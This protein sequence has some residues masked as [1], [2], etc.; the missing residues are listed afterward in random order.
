MP[1]KVLISVTLP[2]S[3]EVLWLS[4][5]ESIYKDRD[6][7]ELVDYVRSLGIEGEWVDT[8][9]SWPL[10][11]QQ[12]FEFT[13]EIYSKHV[14]YPIKFDREHAKKFYENISTGKFIVLIHEID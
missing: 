2:A 5:W 1:E 3:E 14:I 7:K 13:C 8:V 6:I 9:V 4:S 11:D 10:P 12:W